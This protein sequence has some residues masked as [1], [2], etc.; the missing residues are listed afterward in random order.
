MKAYHFTGKKLRDGRGIPKIGEWLVHDGPLEMCSSGLHASR[1]PFD[2]LQYAPGSILHLVE[3]GGE[4]IK[5][6]DKLVARKRKIL[7]SFDAEDLLWEYARQCALDVYH[8]WGNDQTDPKGVCKR[9]LETG[10]EKLGAA[11]WAVAGA[12]AGAAARAAARAV[13]GDAAWDAW[14]AAWDTAWDTAWDAQRKR[15]N[16]MVKDKFKELL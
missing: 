3:V 2:A 9:Y 1:E 15:F 5:G 12:V 6:D 4:I 8:L 16:K 13:A 14:D 7:A 10:D 11:A